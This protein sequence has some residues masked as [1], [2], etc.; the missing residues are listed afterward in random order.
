MSNPA[1]PSLPGPSRPQTFHGSKSFT[2]M[3]PAATSPLARSR[4]ITLQDASRPATINLEE[5]ASPTHGL[6]HGD[7]FER[8]SVGAP[9]GSNSVGAETGEAPE[10]AHGFDNLPIEL[11]SLTDRYCL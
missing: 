10:L 4:A 7:I 2:R 9:D 1:V 5:T 11:V 3:E 8:D 6:Q